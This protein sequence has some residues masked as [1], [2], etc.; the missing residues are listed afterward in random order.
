MLFKTRYNILPAVF[1]LY[2]LP[3]LALGI[4]GTRKAFGNSWEIMSIGLFLVSLGSL[5]LFLL[6]RYW[7]NEIVMKYMVVDETPE[8]EEEITSE[9]DEIIG[10]QQGTEARSQE[11]EIEIV[12]LNHQNEELQSELVEKKQII[13]DLNLQKE[14]LQ[15]S[16]AKVRSEFNQVKESSEEK[17]EQN[18]IF[19]REHQ[20]TITEQRQVIEMKQQQIQQLDDKVRDLTYE[21]KTL[22]HLAEKTQ[23]NDQRNYSPSETSIK[24]SQFEKMTETSASSLQI[25]IGPKGSKE[26]QA[27]LQLKHCI[28]IAQKMTGANHYSSRSGKRAELSMEHYALDLRCLIDSLRNENSCAVLIYSQKENKFI[29][30]NN[31]VKPLL[32]WNAEKFIQ[33]FPSIIEDSVDVWNATLAQ[34]AYKNECQAELSM[35]SK[36]GTL[37]PVK[38][39]LGVIA[40]GI[41]RS[42]I[43]GLLYHAEV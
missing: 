39:Y 35:K 37:I 26:S 20:Q 3:L 12:D 25:P 40:T 32:G 24:N 14:Q 21:I 9:S 16:I 36:N 5:C 11:I 42:N 34:L 28:D 10:L 31:Q 13:Q 8:M 33:N 7:E 43:L 29:F 2:F 17:F 19:L 41:F 23:V 18:Q 15:A 6:L 4:Y 30:G 22:L 27:S 1:M 38:C